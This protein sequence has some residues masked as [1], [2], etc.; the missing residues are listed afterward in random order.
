MAKSKVKNASYWI[1]LN[2]EEPEKVKKNKKKLENTLDAYDDIYYNDIKFEDLDPI[3]DKTYDK[4]I[5]IYEDNFGKRTKIRAEEKNADANEIVQLDYFIASLDKV[6]TE[7]KLNTYLTRVRKDYKSSDLTFTA[8]DKIDGATAVLVAK[9]GKLSLYKGS[10]GFEARD[11]SHIL[12]YVSDISENEKF[13]NV[14]KKDKNFVIRGELVIHNDD[15]AK[16][17]QF[18][19]YAH[20]RTTV[21]GII[22]RKK[23]E[24]EKLEDA[25][26]F[27]FYAFQIISEDIS[28]DEQFDKLKK[29]FGFNTPKYE[30]LEMSDINLESLGNLLKKRR[31]KTK[32]EM[33][34]LVIACNVPEKYPD[35]KNPTHVV[36]FKGDEADGIQTTIKKVIW[37]PDR[38]GY[39]NPVVEFDSVQIDGSSVSRASVFNSRYMEENGVGVGAVVT[40]VKGGDIIPKINTVIEPVEFKAPPHSSPSDNGVK[41]KGDYEYYK[42]EINLKRIIA[43][44]ETLKTKHFS[45][46]TIQ[47]LIDNGYNSVAKI[48][49]VVNDEDYLDKLLEIDTF[50]EKTINKI[51]Q[52]IKDKSNLQIALLMSASSCFE[53]LAEKKLNLILS[54]LTQSDVHS[55]LKSKKVPKEI[56]EKLTNIAGIKKSINVFYDNVK[57]FSKFYNEVKEYLNIDFSVCKIENTSESDSESED[58]LDK[59]RKT[60]K[61]SKKEKQVDVTNVKRLENKT[62]VFS[63]F[64]SEELEKII[65]QHGGKVTSALSKK[66][67]ALIIADKK[68]KTSKDEKAQELGISL[69]HKDN[70][71]DEYINS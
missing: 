48:L 27:H 62:F 63:G 39:L 23:T 15:F 35:D 41:L 51:V 11:I 47:K 21:S 30:I 18:K 66:T 31:E 17:K 36:A 28:A 33:D 6:K 61:S 55:I 8:S 45:E 12:Q 16:E 52:Q 40:I 13:Q 2:K 14:L 38:Y 24:L 49:E 60:P 32:Y 70:F 22:N 50:K 26:F 34:G 7:A 5:A 64:R 69:V 9:N 1:E 59:K 65:S 25:R 67:T 71:I 46:K 54:N 53:S 10:N 19:E 37:E 43:F 3:N 68:K 57:E 58:K 56:T 44:F 42:D 29:H 4:L 20:P